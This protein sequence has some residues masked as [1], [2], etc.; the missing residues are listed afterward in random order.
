MFIMTLLGGYYHQHFT[1]FKKNL[2][3]V[4]L[5]NLS[6]ITQTMSD[7]NRIQA[8]D[9]EFKL[10]TNTLRCIIKCSEISFHNIFFKYLVLHPYVYQGLKHLTK[11]PRRHRMLITVGLRCEAQ[12][13]GDLLVLQIWNQLF[14]YLHL[15][16]FHPPVF[17]VFLY[18]SHLL[19]T[20]SF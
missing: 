14:R 2:E 6:T 20:N 16:L 10:L 5:S 13:W 4:K 18:T 12:R 9:P 17:I 8:I 3:T 15:P 7:S 19:S 1:D 11:K